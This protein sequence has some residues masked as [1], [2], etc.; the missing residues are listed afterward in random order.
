MDLDDFDNHL[1]DEEKDSFEENLEESEFCYLSIS[2]AC[3]KKNYDMAVPE[4]EDKISIAE[5]SHLISDKVHHYL[6]EVL[7]EVQ[8]P[9][10][11]SDFQLLSLHVLDSGK[12]SC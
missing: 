6:Q 10:K 8:L 4:P 1:C 11:L 12:T 2:Q 5:Y 3:S 7:H 9:Y